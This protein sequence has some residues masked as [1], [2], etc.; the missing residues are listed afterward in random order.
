MRIIQGIVYNDAM[1][2][3]NVGQEFLGG[4][5]V[6]LSLYFYGIPVFNHSWINNYVSLQQLL[7]IKQQTVIKEIKV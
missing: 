1:R 4:Q 7:N 3:S 2:R 5:T 6:K